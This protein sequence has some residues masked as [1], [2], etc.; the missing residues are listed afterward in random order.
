M[1]TLTTTTWMNDDL[2]WPHVGQVFRLEGERRIGG[3]KTVEVVYG[4]T[5]LSRDEADVDRLL[6][7]NRAHWGIENGR[8]HTRDETL[9]ED[10]CRVR[11]GN[12]PRVLASLRNVGVYLLRGMGGSSAAA[13]TRELSAHPRKALDP[14][15]APGSTSE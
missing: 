12:A 10:R 14:L 3:Q 9:R 5:S 11:K 7:F 1:R 4:I 2:D 15:H 13:A 6:D 8:H